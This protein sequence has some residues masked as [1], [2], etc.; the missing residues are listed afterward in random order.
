MT[1]ETMRD[2]LIWVVRE[3]YNHQLLLAQTRVARAQAERDDIQQR[4]DAFLDR[5]ND[6]SI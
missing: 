6:E 1:A 5:V 3:E 4:F 2:K